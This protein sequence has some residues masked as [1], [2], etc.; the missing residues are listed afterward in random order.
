MFGHFPLLQWHPNVRPPF[1]SPGT[2]SFAPRASY[3]LPPADP[4][5]AHEPFQL[6]H[7]KTHSSLPRTTVDMAASTTQA[8]KSS[9]KKKA[10]KAIPRPD[11][12]APSTASGAADKGSESQDEGFES[13]YI[14]ELQ[15]YVSYPRRAIVFLRKADTTGRNIRNVN[16]KIVS[17]P[18]VLPTKYTKHL[19]T[20]RGCS[21][22]MPPKPT[23]SWP[24]TLANLSTNWS[25]PR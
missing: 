16:K 13:P 14:K 2:T 5:V 15:K 4:G 8:P 3:R 7:F 22:P 21:R 12:P 9:N 25:P 23:P 17:C 20:Y 6:P 19:V 24:S 1:S 18:Y 11:S 10:L